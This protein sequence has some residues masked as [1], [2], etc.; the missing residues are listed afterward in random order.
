LLATLTELTAIT[1]ADALKPYAPVEVVASGGGVRNP[2]LLAALKSRLPLTLSDEHGLPAQAKEA[3]LMALIGFLTFHQVPLLTGPHVLGRISPGDKPL[4][5][6][7]PAA[8]P[9]GLVMP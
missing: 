2:A 3:Y 9:T 5:L 4:A 6:P 1:V 7:P 8:P